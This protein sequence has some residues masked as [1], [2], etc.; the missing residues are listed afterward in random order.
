MFSVSFYF[1]RPPPETPVD[2]EGKID[3]LVSF[4]VKRRS[5]TS[6]IDGDSQTDVHREQVG[7]HMYILIL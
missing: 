1:T 2:V 4:S 7:R 6:I 3:G 5:P